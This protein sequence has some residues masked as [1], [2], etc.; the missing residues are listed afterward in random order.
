ME[1]VSMAQQ[2]LF[3]NKIFFAIILFLFAR[4]TQTRQGNEMQKFINSFDAGLKMQNGIAY[5]NNEIFS[6][7]VYS[8][9]P[10]TNDTAVISNFSNGKEH[11]NWKKFFATH[12]L[13]EQREFDNGK[14]TG[15][16]IAYWEN[17]KQQ[18][19]YSFLNDEYEGSC[20]EW[21]RDGNLIK[22]MNYKTGHE[23]GPQKMFYDNGKV[24]SNY[25]IING[26]R[27]G[28]LGTKNCVN[29]SDSI[30]KK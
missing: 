19:H 21:N 1:V 8:L 20:R 10:G 2:V 18:L 9:F 30:F 7:T 26:R 15:N 14:K 17:G 5:Y 11:G 16:Y 4:C 28:L 3:R 12:L 23:E 22:E 27:Y 29:V 6:G 24:R 25:M 13:K